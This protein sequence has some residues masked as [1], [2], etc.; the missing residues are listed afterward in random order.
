MSKRLFRKVS[1]KSTKKK[2]KKFK[3][4]KTNKINKIKNKKKIKQ[5]KE[6]KAQPSFFLQKDSIHYFDNTNYLLQDSNE[7]QEIN[8]PNDLNILEPTEKKEQNKNSF[9]EDFTG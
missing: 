9:S 4:L 1:K 5:K 7:S 2:Q 3:K 8:F 6:K